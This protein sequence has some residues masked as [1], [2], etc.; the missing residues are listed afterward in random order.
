MSQNLWQIKFQRMEL[1]RLA[2]KIRGLTSE[3]ECYRHA[4]DC[5]RVLMKYDDVR[6]AKK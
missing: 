3:A 1:Q 6:K 2:A 4:R 5:Y